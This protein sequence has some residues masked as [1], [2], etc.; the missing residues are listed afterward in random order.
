MCGRTRWTREDVVTSTQDVARDL[1]DRGAIMERAVVLARCQSGGRGRGGKAWTSPP[2]GLWMTL[3]S[4]LASDIS[5]RGLYPLVAGISAVDAVEHVTG[6]RPHL[7]WPNDLLLGEGK[8]GGILCETAGPFVLV[9]LGVNVCTGAMRIPS[10]PGSLQPVDLS[11]ARPDMNC[12]EARGWVEAIARAFDV[13]MCAWEDC[14][15]SRPSEILDAWKERSQMI[16]ARV[17]V[18]TGR[19]QFCATVLDLDVSGGLMVVDEAGSSRILH[20]ADVSVRL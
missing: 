11:R 10:P 6:L 1:I 14:I 17:E 4:R 12:S 2:G 15:G 13:R 18:R 5:R 3:V 16:G 19:E 9:G 20:S 7:K 8:L